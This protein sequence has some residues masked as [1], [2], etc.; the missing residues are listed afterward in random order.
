[1]GSWVSCW[2]PAWC[3]PPEISG[4]GGPPEAVEP[5]GGVHGPLYTDELAL[6]DGEVKLVEERHYRLV[7]A[8]G[9]DSSDLAFYAQ[10]G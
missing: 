1:M 2:S 5:A 6:A 3:A 8:Q 4:A 10:R 7:P 9:I